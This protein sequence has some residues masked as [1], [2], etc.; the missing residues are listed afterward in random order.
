MFTIN[1]KLMILQERLY[2]ITAAFANTESYAKFGI[3]M[4][5]DAEMAK[6]LIESI[7]KL[8]ADIKV[9]IIKLYEEQPHE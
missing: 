4:Q 7:E 8:S 2:A 6:E 1:E 5:P 3:E 9:D